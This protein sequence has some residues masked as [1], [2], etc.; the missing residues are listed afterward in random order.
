MMS[1]G[2]FCQCELDRA[3]YVFIAIIAFRVPVRRW[4]DVRRVLMGWV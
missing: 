3:R 2:P 1:R 4:S